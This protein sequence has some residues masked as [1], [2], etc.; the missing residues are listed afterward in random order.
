MRTITLRILASIAS[1]SCYDVG[2]HVHGNAQNDHSQ[3]RKD[4]QASGGLCGKLRH[5]RLCWLTRLGIG[6]ALVC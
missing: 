2:A 1:K 5:D 3:S 4:G 6:H